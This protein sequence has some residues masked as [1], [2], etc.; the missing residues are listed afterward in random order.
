MTDPELLEKI[1][2]DPAEF[3]ILFREHYKPIFGYVFRRT[4]DVDESADI[5]AETFYKA[6]KYT[7]TFTYKGISLKVWLY[8]IA[9]NELNMFFRHKRHSLLD[10]IDSFAQFT[11]S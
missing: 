10:R 4:G 2:N 3:S 7:N 11:R 6:L 5:A 9:T 8:R 1:R